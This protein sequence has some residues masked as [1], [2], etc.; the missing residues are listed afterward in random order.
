MLPSLLTDV[1]SIATIMST[2]VQPDRHPVASSMDFAPAPLPDELTLSYRA[3]GLHT[4]VTIPMLMRRNLYE[5]SEAPCAIDGERTLTWRQMLDSAFRL[6]G[7]LLSRGVGPGDVVVWQLPNWWEALAVAYGVWA[8]GAV[9]APVVPT[10]REHELGGVLAAV[11]PAGVIVAERFRHTDHVELMEEAIRSTGS[12]PKARVVVRGSAT[13][14]TT[15]EEALRSPPIGVEPVDAGAPSL[16]GFTSGTTSGSK[17]VVMSTRTMLAVPLRHVRAV[18]YSWKDRG[19]MPAPV[20]HATGLLMAVTIPLVSGCSAV[21]ADR[22]DAERA[23]ADINRHHVTYSAG[24]EVFIRELVAA[25]EAAGLDALPLT[26]GYNCGG[27]AI[28]AEVAGRGER[29]QMN[30]RRAYGLTECPTV[31][32]SSTLDPPDVRLATDGRILPGCEVRVISDEGRD[33]PPGS[34]GEFLVRG[35]QRALGYVDPVHTLEAFDEA[36]WLRTG[37]VGWVDS[38]GYLRVT[39]RIKDIINRGGEKL[40]AREIEE[41]ISRHPAVR[42]VAV[43]AVP[44]PRLGEEPAAFVIVDED[45]PSDVGLA[46]FLRKSGLAPYK[47][48]RRWVRVDRLPRTPSGKVMKHELVARL[49]ADP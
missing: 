19:Y 26:T 28:P 14:W 25:V 39:G 40:S 12:V 37:D 7:F 31:S 43:T 47:I 18:P 13:G 48:P 34:T 44:H 16:V 41:A 45:G 10:Y 49:P 24:A 33:L 46:D 9:S 27:S 42:E 4:D 38:A 23:V 11:R 20:S 15:W 29:L 30:P 5:F 21:L 6:A 22:W 3:S 17:A 32:A 35:P 8:V 36:G 2:D 1:I